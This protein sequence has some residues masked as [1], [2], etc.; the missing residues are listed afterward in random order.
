MSMAKA[1]PQNIVDGH[2]EVFGRWHLVCEFR[3][4]IKILVAEVGQDLAL[5][6]SVEIHQVAYHAGA[7]VHPS[8]YGDLELVIVSVAVRVIALA[9]GLA[10][11]RVGHLRAVQAV[12]GRE[13]VAPGKVILHASP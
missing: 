10:V 13:Q 9:V 7:R 4:G 2:A 12:R 1:A 8:A 6:E 5:D 11:P 3:Q